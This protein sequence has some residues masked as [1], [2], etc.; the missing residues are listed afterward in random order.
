M[1]VSLH[2]TLEFSSCLD[3]DAIDYP[4]GFMAIGNRFTVWV[5]RKTFLLSPQV[6]RN[7]LIRE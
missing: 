4:V 1:V 3:N 6:K 2:P 7:W 5:H